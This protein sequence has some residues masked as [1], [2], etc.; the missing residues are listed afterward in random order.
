MPRPLARIFP[1]GRLEAGPRLRYLCKRS[2]AVP[3]TSRA[4]KRTVPLATDLGER[5][6]RR[7]QRIGFE[8]RS[9]RGRPF[10]FSGVADEFAREAAID[11]VGVANVHPLLYAAP[12]D[13][14]GYRARHPRRSAAEN[15]I[16]NVAVVENGYV[17][18]LHRRTAL[19]QLDMHTAIGYLERPEEAERRERTWIEVMDLIERLTARTG[20]ID[21]HSYKPKRALV[22]LSICATEIAL[23]ETHVI[24]LERITLYLAGPGIGLRHH[25]ANVRDPD[26]PIEV[27]DRARL[28]VNRINR[29]R[30]ENVVGAAEHRGAA[31]IGTGANVPGA[32][33]AG[34]G[35][36][37]VEPSAPP[38]AA[39]PASAR[40]N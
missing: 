36:S 3:L 28:C 37:N 35:F 17:G 11:R 32:A 27:G 31:G 38:T 18:C 1:S 39:V 20:L 9:D 13:L 5:A 4:G 2:P 22:D 23:H 29:A 25:A 16:R 14:E 34:A 24:V 19:A 26:K 33:I 30:A 12:E 10:H 21:V 40:P 8:L 7:R 15:R 6:E